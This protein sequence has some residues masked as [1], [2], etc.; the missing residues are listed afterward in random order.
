MLS[1]YIC[2]A[3][4]EGLMLYPDMDKG[5]TGQE[6]RGEGPNWLFMTDPLSDPLS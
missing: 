5:I 3:A 2:S 6:G 1:S 4:V